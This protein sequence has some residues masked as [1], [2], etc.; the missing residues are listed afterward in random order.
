MAAFRDLTGQRFGKLLILQRAPSRRS[1]SGHLGV[2]W[3]CQCDCGEVKEIPASSFSTRKARSCGCATREAFIARSTTHGM[4]KHPLFRLWRAMLDRVDGKNGRR[5]YA[6]RGIDMDPRWRDFR[7]F[8]HDVGE[9]PS[10]RHSL[11]RRDNNQGYWPGNVRWALPI[12]QQSNTRR[13]VFLEYQGRRLTLAQWS[14]EIGLATGALTR[15][16]ARGLPIELLL[17]PSA[18]QPTH[19]VAAITAAYESGLSLAEVGQR[20]GISDETVRQIL[21][22]AGV[23]RRRPARRNP[24]HAVS[25]GG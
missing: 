19:D 22:G 4:S 21:K 11:D 23:P 16:M 5:L 18:K 10:P 12:E 8:L 7:A 14:R 15:R 2:Y 25:P 13:N 3:L 24:A 6:D 9:R 1:P 17:A 20:F